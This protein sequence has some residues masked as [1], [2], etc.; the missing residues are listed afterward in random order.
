MV[1]VTG[2]SNPSHPIDSQGSMGWDDIFELMNVNFI[3]IGRIPS[4]CIFI[5]KED[6]DYLKEYGFIAKIKEDLMQ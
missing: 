1:K 2:F 4:E 3:A 6:V 5:H